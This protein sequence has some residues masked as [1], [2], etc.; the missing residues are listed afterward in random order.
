MQQDHHAG[1][2]V[3]GV[4]RASHSAP[5]NEPIE[6]VLRTLQCICEIANIP[7]L[8]Q[9]R[10]QLLSDPAAI[11]VMDTQAPSSDAEDVHRLLQLHY[12]ISTL[13]TISWATGYHVALQQLRYNEHFKALVKRNHTR[14][15]KARNE[16]RNCKKR[17]TTKDIPLGSNPPPLS[18]V[19]IEVLVKRQILSSMIEH[20]IS[21]RVAKDDLEKYPE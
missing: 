18:P 15:A 3:Q 6:K 2:N 11:A 5:A 4:I 7:L 20:G 21:E 19:R 10:E 17:R 13:C 8:L 16:R 14:A 9:V 1:F 12:D